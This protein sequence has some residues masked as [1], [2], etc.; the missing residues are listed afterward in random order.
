MTTIDPLPFIP[1]KNDERVVV[2]TD[3]C[4]H[5]YKIYNDMKTALQ[6][7]PKPFFVRYYQHKRTL[8]LTSSS[9]EYQQDCM[10]L[11][12]PLTMEEYTEHIK[13][14]PNFGDNKHVTIQP[15]VYRGDP[16]P[17]PLPG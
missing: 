8:E 4:Y 17:L 7:L 14:N 3:I 12:Y 6:A 5:E 13:D 2:F 1:L 10:T 16:T 9:E 15:I 11:L